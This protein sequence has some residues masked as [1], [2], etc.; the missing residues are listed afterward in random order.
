[1]KIMNISNYSIGKTNQNTPAFKS[2]ILV[3][4]QHAAEKRKVL[5]FME[6]LGEALYKT[7]TDNIDLLR[8]SEGSAALELPTTP[9]NAKL[10][11]ILQSDIRTKFQEKNIDA[12]VLAWA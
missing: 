8:F 2:S 5:P 1:M 12:A 4:T 3:Y 7:G 6:M 10:V 9:E 11:R